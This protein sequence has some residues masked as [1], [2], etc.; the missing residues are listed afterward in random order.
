MLKLR[1]S[2][3]IFQD[4]IKLKLIKRNNLKILFHKTRDKKIRV[5]QDQKS[6]IIYLEEDVNNEKKYIKKP[7]SPYFQHLQKIKKLKVLK[8][9]KNRFNLFKKE[10]K[11]KKI[12]DYGCGMGGFLSL[13]NKISK[14]CE[15]YEIMQISQKEINKKK[16]FKLNTTKSDLKGK[17]FD[18]IFLF[19]VL[20]HMSEQLKELK[21]LRNLLT[22][23]GKLIIEVPHSLDAL[24]VNK[25]L[26]SFKEFTFWS[27]HL[28]LHTKDSLK[29][30]LIHSGFKRVKFINY[31]RYDFE[32][33]LNWFIKK[34]PN[35]H[36]KPLFKVDIKTKK[37]YEK[38]LF[39]NNISDTLIAV[40]SK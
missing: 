33:H 40:A 12:L 37:N 3:P 25:E 1:I 15:G 8:D 28:I 36:I 6:K 7:S 9:D 18:R 39:K 27:E 11:N 5:L 31:Q 24:I 19:H 20:E 29:K 4:L 2:N 14:L 34:K 30:F 23:N 32:N 17:K 22:I 16:L 10:I 38:Y 26:N 13:A 35:G 21:Y